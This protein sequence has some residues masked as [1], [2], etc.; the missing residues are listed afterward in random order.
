[1][2]YPK[3]KAGYHNAACCIC[4]PDGGPGI[5]VTAMQRYLCR[6]D[7]ELMG[8]LCYPKCKAGYHNVGT[9][10]CEPDGGP[11][12]KVTVMQRYQCTADEEL[13]GA[14]CYPKCKAGFHAVGCCSCSQDCFPGSGDDIGVS[15]TKKTTTRGAGV[16]MGCPTGTIADETGGP[17]GLCYPECKTDF[18]GIGPVCWQN[19]P[20]GMT[21]CAA[22][23]SKDALE[24]ASTTFDQVFAV[25]V[26]AANIV[27]L[28]MA[29]EVTGPLKAG[30]E[31]IKLGNKAVRVTSKVGKYFVKAVDLLQSTSKAGLATDATIIKRIINVK[32]GTILSKVFTAKKVV[33][34]AYKAYKDYSKAVAED[35]VDQTSAEIN[36]RVDDNFDPAIAKYIKESWGDVQMARMSKTNDFVIAQDVLSA[37]AIVDITGVTGVVSAFLK[38]ICGKNVPFP[39]LSKNYQ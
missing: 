8:A 24:C 15:C 33:S 37:V 29:G 7:E 26:L 19:C 5:K 36:K 2:W 25:V 3:C 1:M 13:N 16:P 9:N 4:E 23:C 34:T 6:S 17:V 28:G 39:T 18:H 35:F 32:T 21:D 27:T 30:E 14:L 38:P 22:G 10:L 20:N 11:G 31:A 12:I